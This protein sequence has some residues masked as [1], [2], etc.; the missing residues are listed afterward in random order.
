MSHP[1]CRILAYII[2]LS[3]QKKTEK[4]F[5]TNHNHSIR[6]FSVCLEASNKN[7]ARARDKQLRV[8]RETSPK[9]QPVNPTPTWQT[10]V[11][12]EES[13]TPSLIN[14]CNEEP[15]M[16]HG[17]EWDFIYRWFNPKWTKKTKDRILE[18]GGKP[19]GAAFFSFAGCKFGGGECVHILDKTCLGT[20]ETMNDE[21]II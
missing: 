12:S 5:E 8:S 6:C 9:G 2:Y 10:Q 7:V 13:S 15:T 1:I 21:S 17:Y 11:G 4:P 14:S 20:R 19:V 3:L 16:E 18:K